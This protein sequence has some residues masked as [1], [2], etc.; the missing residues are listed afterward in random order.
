MRCGRVIVLLV[1]LLE[2]WVVMG[3]RVRVGFGEGRRRGEGVVMVLRRARRSV[4][5]GGCIFILMGVVTR[6]K[7]AVL[8]VSVVG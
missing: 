7:V 6:G 8:Y 4:G 3:R 2:R 1:L 5:D